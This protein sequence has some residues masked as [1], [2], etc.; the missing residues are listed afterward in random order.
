MAEV[1]EVTIW[2]TGVLQDMEGR[3]ASLLIANAADKEGKF[4]QAWDNYADLPDL[5]LIHI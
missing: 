2:A 1:F 4:V 3:H 5:S